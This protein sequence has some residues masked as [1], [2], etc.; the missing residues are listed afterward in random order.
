MQAGKIVKGG[1]HSLG[2]AA[3]LGILSA[4]GGSATPAQAGSFRVNP[5]HIA[6]PPDRQSTTVTITNSGFVP[7]SVR[8]QGYSWTQ[9]GG[10]DVHAST[11]HVI[12]SPPIFTIPAGKT[13][14]VRVGIKSRTA[15]GAYRLVLEEIPRDKPVEGQVQVNLRLNLPLYVM[16]KGD[17][18]VDLT[19]AAWRD[20]S[21]NVVVQG[22]NR[23]NLHG[24]VLK[25]E[26]DDGSSRQLL[27]NQ[28]GVVLP[29]SARNWNI[30]KRPGFKAGTLLTLRVRS[31]AG[32]TQTRIAVQQR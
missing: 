27:S 15:E 10:E 2:M 29:G 7:V 28:M 18:K 19:W 26:A 5:V 32:E 1:G 9:Q 20:S 21:G 6:L 23:G 4:F 24:Q 22:R 11:D 14:L 13:Q 8:A 25:I 17:G 30:G 31:P 16:P 3:T 12:A